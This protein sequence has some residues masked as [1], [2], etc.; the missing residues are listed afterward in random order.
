MA[1]VTHIPLE[2]YL[3]SSYEPDAEYVEG[4][5]EERPMGEIQHA[6]WQD[7][8]Q[9]WFR[10]H[11]AEWNV[12]A[13]PEVRVQIAADRFRVPDVVVLRPSQL[14]E[15]IVKTAPVAVFE[16][17]SPA[18]TFRRTIEKLPNYELM[19]INNIWVID[20]ESR[21]YYRFHQ[22]KLGIATHFGDPG[23]T[24]YFAMKDLET[25]LS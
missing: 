19:G 1:T 15:H 9:A 5:L 13:L 22:G 21:T 12:R 2:V 17:L 7:A 16:I 25:L 14:L 24:I 10:A 18:D 3:H 23:D 4:H 20:P 11:T 6:L 8:L